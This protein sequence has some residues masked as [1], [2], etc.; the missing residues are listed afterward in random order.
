MRRARVSGV[1]ALTLAGS[2][3]SFLLYTPTIARGD[4]LGMAVPSMSAAPTSTS[5][6]PSLGT[7]FETALNTRITG[8][9]LLSLGVDGV[10]EVLGGL[11][12]AKM[13]WAAISDGVDPFSSEGLAGFLT[14][15]TSGILHDNVEPFPWQVGGS[16]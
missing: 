13:V 15:K 2:V 3:E 11:G 16:V 7:K 12:R 5:S 14:D 4:V 6:A 10:S 1:T 8:G 9:E